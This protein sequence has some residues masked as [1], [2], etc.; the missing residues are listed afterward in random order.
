MKE[1]EIGK[2]KRKK[3]RKKGEPP[4]IYILFL[5]KG[6]GKVETNDENRIRRYL[7]TWILNMPFPITF[8]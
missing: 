7:I 8:E 4:I 6:K 3:V 1:K 2:S 5:D